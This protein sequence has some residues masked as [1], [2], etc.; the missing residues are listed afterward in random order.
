VF[1]TAPGA[2]GRDFLILAVGNDSQFAKFCEAA[3]RAELASD[4]RFAK[5][6]D[7]VRNRAVLVPILE[8]VMR[9]RT[10]A[11]WLAGLEIARVPCG[12]INNIAEVFE[13]VQVNERGMVNTWAHPLRD[14]VRLVA[15][16]I[17][18]SG[19]PVRTDMPPPLLG[20]HTDEV[21]RDVLRW[22]EQ[23]IAAARER[24]AV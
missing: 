2:A 1:E 21:L 16:P 12:P 11:Q 18:M 5:N 23:R 19:T 14:A 24:K 6:Q 22:D 3:G 13:D 9:T 8:A 4:A 15:S 7:R 17:R 10:K 20:Q